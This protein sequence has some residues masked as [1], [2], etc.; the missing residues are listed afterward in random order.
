MRQKRKINSF[1]LVLSVTTILCSALLFAT[2]TVFAEQIVGT[3][4]NSGTDSRI[5]GTYDRLKSL[6]F[7][8]ESEGL[9]GDWG[10]YWNRIRS[11]AEWTPSTATATETEVLPGYTF[12]AGSN[13]TLKTGT[14]VVGKYDEQKYCR[15]DDWFAGASTANENI[16]EESVWTLTAQGG[17]SV[18][19]T[20]NGITVT[21]ASNQVYQDNLT[22][23]YWSDRA[24]SSLDNEFQW[25]IGDDPV[26][27]SSTSCNFLSAG[28]AN[29]YCDNRDPT[30]A[31]AEDNDVSAAE[32]C[33]NLQLD[34]DN[35]DGDNNGATGVETDWYL[36]TQKQLMQAYIDGS[37]NHLPRADVNF[38]SSSEYSSNRS[39]AWVVNLPNGYT[40]YNNKSSNYYVRC[41]RGTSN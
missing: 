22:G 24:N 12:Y 18:S 33:L 32:F 27:P 30:N 8:S 4:P 7:G 26:N 28:T 13:R 3:T 10:A 21:I 37:A 23:L 41:I 31:Y 15:Y 38:W 17:S 40:H 39:N 25:E 19:V 36:P 2:F 1:F 5:K 14:A 9:W 34:A 6:E 35:A 29:S 20:D 11:S 16:S